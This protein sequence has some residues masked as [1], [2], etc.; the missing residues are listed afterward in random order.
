M[1]NGRTVI[2]HVLY[3]NGKLNDGNNNDNDQHS[4]S[5]NN[6]TYNENNTISEMVASVMSKRNVGHRAA[7]Q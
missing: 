6:N 5:S 4:T 2:R 1:Q 7:E 3:K